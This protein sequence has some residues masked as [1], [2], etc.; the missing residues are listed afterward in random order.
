MEFPK[1]VNLSPKPLDSNV[2]SGRFHVTAVSRSSADLEN[3]KS[4][5]YR[6]DDFK[7]LIEVIKKLPS[8]IC[9]VSFELVGVYYYDL[10]FNLLDKS[11]ILPFDLDVFLYCIYGTP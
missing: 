5:Y 4:F 6:C 7:T 9:P 2:I 11:V 1:V 3:L 10:Y 8:S